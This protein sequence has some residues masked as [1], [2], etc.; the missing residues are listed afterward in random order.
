M[1]I[2]IPL[3][4][5][6]DFVAKLIDKFVRDIRL[7]LLITDF[8][9]LNLWIQ[10]EFGFSSAVSCKEIIE[11]AFEHIDVITTQTHYKIVINPITY[12]PGTS[13]RLITLLKTINYG[14][15]HFKGIPIIADECKLLNNNLDDL[16]TQYEFTG[17]VF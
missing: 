12:Y 9:L 4:F 15:R 17:M 2:L 7:K 3:K 8:R 10:V 16:Y 13:I 6:A 5:N 14:T 11:Y 1:S